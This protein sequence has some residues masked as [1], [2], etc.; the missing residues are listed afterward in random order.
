MGGSGIM[1]E[2]CKENS[3][4]QRGLRVQGAVV[5][6]VYVVA[7]VWGERAMRLRLTTKGAWLA[8]QRIAQ[9]LTLSVAFASPMLLVMSA[10]FLGGT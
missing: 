7:G 8:W 6:V 10:R 2:M 9:G 5:A 1:H 4:E 3:R